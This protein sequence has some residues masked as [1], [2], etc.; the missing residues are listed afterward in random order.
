[1]YI[2]QAA[3][4]AKISPTL[5]ARPTRIF[6]GVPAAQSTTGHGCPSFYPISACM[7]CLLPQHHLHSLLVSSILSSG[8]YYLVS[9]PGY[10]SIS[11]PAYL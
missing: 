3:L 10:F 7:G 9:I 2:V 5:A 4:A 11:R 1:M 8:I 6:P